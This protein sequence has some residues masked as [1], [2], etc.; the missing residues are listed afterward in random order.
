MAPMA[1]E[2]L[3]PVGSPE[4]KIRARTRAA[5]LEAALELFAERGTDGTALHEVAARAGVSNG[6]FYNYFRT[7]EQLVEAA[8]G[9]LARR[10]NETVAAAYASVA[11]PVERVSIGCRA[12][13][14]H[15]RRDPTWGRAVLRSWGTSEHV[16]ERAVEN[17]IA[18]LRAG[19]RAGSFDYE[20]ERAAVDLVQGAVL[21]GMRSLLEGRV[22]ASHAAAVVRHVLRGL[23]VPARIAKATVAR[24]MPS[25]LAPS[26]PGRTPHAQHASDLG[27][28]AF[29]DA[30]RAGR[31]K[32]VRSLPT[33]TPR[34]R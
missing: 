5:L 30:N 3:R 24:P 2:A 11:D 32:R 34:S 12:F 27:A 1:R 26:P 4:T 28:S 23:G 18:D 14:L 7:R 20:Q 9:L 22:E 21:A 16:S 31:K 15:A 10:L 29:I 33:H 8:N 17:L 13:L 6:T 19:K 25:Q